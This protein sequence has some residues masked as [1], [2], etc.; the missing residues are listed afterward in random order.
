MNG[1]PTTYIINFY[2]ADVNLATLT[3]YLHDSREII[4]YWNYIPLVYCIKSYLSAEE[5]VVRL[6]PF[7]PHP[8]MI[9]EINSGNINGI[10]PQEA[11]SWFYMEHHEKQH[12]IPNLGD[13]STLG[14]LLRLRPR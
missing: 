8:F 7:F 5:L 9:A 14:N 10:L 11:W 3:R 4:A 2:A 12:E 1:K 6:H 13:L